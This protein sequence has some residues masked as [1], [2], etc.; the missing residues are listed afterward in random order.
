MSDEERRIMQSELA[1]KKRRA[2]ECG[3]RIHDLVEDRLFSDFQDLP[4]LAAQAVNACEAWHQARQ[5][6]DT[7]GEGS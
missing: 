3:A 7:A 4:A 2:D 1:I 5:R 6:L